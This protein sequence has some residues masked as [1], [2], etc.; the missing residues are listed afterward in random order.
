[1]ET[2]EE[3]DTG[4]GAAVVVRGVVVAWFAEFN[5]SARD[6]CTHNHFG[7][8]L[9]WRAKPP[10]I[11]P[12]TKSEYDEAMREANELAELFAAMPEASN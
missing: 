11:V 4:L 12:L 2:K 3:L 5:E 8:W 6:W 7:E 10:E 1:M 9:A